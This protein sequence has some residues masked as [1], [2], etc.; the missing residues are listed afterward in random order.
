MIVMSD[1]NADPTHDEPTRTEAVTGNSRVV[2]AARSSAARVGRCVRS[3]LLYRRLTAEPDPEVIVID[4]RETRTAGPILA[5]LDWVISQLSRGF[6]NSRIGTVARV[7]AGGTR[8]RPLAALG[9][10][11]V[12]LGSA[13]A[14]RTLLTTGPEPTLTLV[15]AV[16]TTLTGVA[17]TRDER[18]W[19]TLRE[20]ETVKLLVR[21]LEPPDP[22]ADSENSGVS[23]S[24]VNDE[25]KAS[26]PDSSE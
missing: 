6:E 11:V 25:G 3:S 21:V 17:L 7:T 1:T 4:L 16:I 18:D 2:A 9:L 20:T 15:A 24:G 12:A 19:E 22:P 10:V 13:I 14:A 26:D 23:E 8:S 5:V